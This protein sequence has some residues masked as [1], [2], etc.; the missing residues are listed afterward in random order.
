MDDKD[1]EI[2]RLRHALCMLRW[3]YAN[4]KM[5]ELEWSRHFGWHDEWEIWHRTAAMARTMAGA[6]KEVK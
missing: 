3:Q 2:R 5:Q 6:C 4:Q 1:M